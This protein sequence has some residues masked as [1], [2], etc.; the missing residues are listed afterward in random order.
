MSLENF[1]WEK[2]SVKW[3]VTKNFFSLKFFTFSPLSTTGLIMTPLYAD[4]SFPSTEICW[5]LNLYFSGIHLGCFFI[6]HYLTVSEKTGQ[7]WI[8]RSHPALSRDQKIAFSFSVCKWEWRIYTNTTISNSTTVPYYTQLKLF[9]SSLLTT[10]LDIM[11]EIYIVFYYFR[12]VN[13]K[14][15]P[16]ENK[17]RLI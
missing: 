5:S 8:L 12:T 10:Q 17:L 15:V 4:V 2:T 16:G 3:C 14:W 9:S 13:H 6:K 11:M 1:R 7:H